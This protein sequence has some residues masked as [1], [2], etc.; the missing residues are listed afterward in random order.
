M[1]NVTE[2]YSS[3]SIGAS[4]LRITFYP[5]AVILGIF[6]NIITLKILLRGPKSTTNWYLK[7]L[8]IADLAFVLVS[9]LFFFI[10][11]V[12]DFKVDLR[13]FVKCSFITFCFHYSSYCSS[14]NLVAVTVDRFIAIYFPLRSKTISTRT[15]A[16]YTTLILAII[17]FGFCSFML[18]GLEI[19]PANDYKNLHY[20]IRCV[21]KTRSLSKF[22]LKTF[23]ILD[24]SLYSLIPAT[25]I[26]IFNLL[27]ILKLRRA[28]AVG[29]SVGGKVIRKVS[30]KTTK[31]LLTISMTFILLSCPS[32]VLSILINIPGYL[33]T[34]YDY[35]VFEVLLAVSDC[36]SLTNHCINFILYI[37][38]G[39]EFRKELVKMC[40]VDGAVDEDRTMG[41]AGGKSD[42]T[43][44]FVG[45]RSDQTIGIVSTRTSRNP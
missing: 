27:I 25:L 36:L 34:S 9:A 28:V 7:I 40:A 20:S 31:T 8:S 45:G 18:G 12:T 13:M 43:M 41:F 1:A 39:T 26:L 19:N 37:L 23:P 22:L 30:K 38:T 21:G 17:F 24:F 44:G 42:Q 16:K 33:K 3:Y 15:T 32:C 11:S 2:D 35:A 5:S 29:P 14:W 4:K 10:L 6:G